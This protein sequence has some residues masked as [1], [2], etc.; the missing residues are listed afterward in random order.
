V[1]VWIMVRRKLTI[2][3]RWQTVGMH[4][5]GFSNR[6]VADNFRVNHSIIVRLMQ[7]FRQTGNVIDRPRELPRSAP[8]VLN[9]RCRACLDMSQSSLGVVFRSL[10]ARGRSVTFKFNFLLVWYGAANINH[11]RKVA[12]YWHA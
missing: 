4:S 9:G 11:A 3:E 6:R 12:S 8:A 2:P 7:R 1:P 10:P 5:G